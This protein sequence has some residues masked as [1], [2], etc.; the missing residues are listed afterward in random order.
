MK[1][2]IT[3]FIYGFAVISIC[4]LSSG[5]TDLPEDTRRFTVTDDNG[6]KVYNLKWDRSGF[7]F[8]RFL[9]EEGKM[10]VLTGS[11]TIWEQ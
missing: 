8:D 2:E 9:T 10:L 6:E 1:N 7:G 3:K 4:L 11:Y 5:C